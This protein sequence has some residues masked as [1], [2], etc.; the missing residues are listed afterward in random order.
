[1]RKSLEFTIIVRN[2]CVFETKPDVAHWFDRFYR[3]DQS[4]S[5]HTGGTGIGLSKAQAI[6]EAH[7]GNIS[8]KVENGN[9]VV[10]K[11]IL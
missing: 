6:V 5:V 9:A 3:P 4:R 7:K 10:F 2:T 11:V 1:M 8:A